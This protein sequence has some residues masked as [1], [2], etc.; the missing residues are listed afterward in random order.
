MMVRTLLMTV[1]FGLACVY[2]YAQFDASKIDIVR[3][4]WGVPHIFANTERFYRMTFSRRRIRFPRSGV[5]YSQPDV[6]ITKLIQPIA[7]AHLE[8]VSRRKVK[9]WF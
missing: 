4:K 6:D 7:A 1:V 5:S 2:A 8:A 9:S 3:D